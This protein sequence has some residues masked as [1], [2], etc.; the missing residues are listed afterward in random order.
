[1]AGT[2]APPPFRGVLVESLGV[3]ESRPPISPTPGLNL[4][5]ALPKLKFMD[6]PGGWRIQKFKCR[7]RL[8]RKVHLAPRFKLWLILGT[9]AGLFITALLALMLAWGPPPV[10]ETPKAATTHGNLSDSRPIVAPLHTLAGTTGLPPGI[11]DVRSDSNTP[12]LAF[13]SG[14]AF[15]MSFGALW[16]A[17]RRHGAGVPKLVSTGLSTRQKVSPAVS[18]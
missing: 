16:A 13:S 6:R 8:M 12:V 10:F 11:F 9:T 2:D 14:L 17:R 1:M 7:D 18:L 3:L 4:R 5:F 15:A